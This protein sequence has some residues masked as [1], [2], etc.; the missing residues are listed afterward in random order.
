MSGSRVS[1][2]NGTAVTWGS[3]IHDRSAPTEVVDNR[4][5]DRDWTC[6]YTVRLQESHEK[7][8][9]T[10]NIRYI[11]QD[12]SA[13]D[14]REGNGL[15]KDCCQH[16]WYSPHNKPFIFAFS[17]QPPWHVTIWAKQSIHDVCEHAWSAKIAI[18][19]DIFTLKFCRR[20][21]EKPATCFTEKEMRQIF[22]LLYNENARN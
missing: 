1:G 12:I 22:S 6:L 15:D 7:E 13:S 8:H 5:T 20:I 4:W 18:I 9:K 11:R 17:M 10:G 3:A 14:A 2:G 21:T 19:N 16:T